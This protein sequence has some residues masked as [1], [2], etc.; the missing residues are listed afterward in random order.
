MN[1][2]TPAIEIR[3]KDLATNAAALRE[4]LARIVVDIS[5]VVDIRYGLGGWAQVVRGRW[6]LARI[7]GYEQ[8][9]ATADRCWTDN[10]VEL[11]RER[12]MPENAPGCELLLADFNTLTML[13]RGLLDEALAACRPS[14]V[15]FTD[16]A[17]C[18]LHLNYRSYGLKAANLEQYWTAFRIDGYRRLRFSRLHHAAS[19]AVYAQK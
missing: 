13:K 12:F 18:K 8:H 19:T 17:C 4:C 11:R 3:E 5:S 10:R 9:P 7:V 14:Y 6:P 16:V 1:Q 2:D 15:V